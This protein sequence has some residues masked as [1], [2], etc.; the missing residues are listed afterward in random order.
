MFNY[1]IDSWEWEDLN[2]E[3]SN[4]LKDRINSLYEFWTT[5]NC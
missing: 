2:D 5:N 4:I 1:G 3:L